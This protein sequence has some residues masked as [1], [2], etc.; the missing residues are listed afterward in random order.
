ML[1]IFSETIHCAF[2]AVVIAELGGEWQ[3]LATSG[4]NNGICG[5]AV[6]NHIVLLFGPHTGK[7]HLTIAAVGKR[8]VIGKAWTEVVESPFE[9]TE[10]LEL[11]ALDFDGDPQ[12]P[13]I[14]IPKGT[15]RLRY[16]ALDFRDT[17]MDGGPEQ[18]YEL[19][20]WRSAL[21][22]DKVIKVTSPA[23]AYWHY[24]VMNLDRP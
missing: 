11:R 24:P 13:S 12:G 10:H 9:A 6:S 3:E 20:F 14:F 7:V 1:T 15:Y 5:S 22:E 8:P 17:G 19:L 2:H 23:A 4:Q 18:R 16:C 21:T